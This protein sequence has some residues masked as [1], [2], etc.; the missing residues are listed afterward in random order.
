MNMQPDHQLAIA[1]SL[2]LMPTI[3]GIST[4]PTNKRGKK[5]DDVQAEITKKV[6]RR[7]SLKKQ[8]EAQNRG[9]MQFRLPAKG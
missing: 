2:P 3:G 5:K 9:S 4:I 7:R 1:P 6:S 8:R